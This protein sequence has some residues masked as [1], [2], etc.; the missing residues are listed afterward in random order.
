MTPAPFTHD[1]LRRLG[2]CPE[3]SRCPYCPAETPCHWIHWGHYQR[4]AGDPE[5]PSR[6]VAVP[7]YW[8]KIVTRTFSQLPDALLPYCSLR[9][10]QVL[11]WLRALYVER[12]DFLDELSD[13]QR[14]LGI[15]VSLRRQR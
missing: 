14:Q 15:P 13:A 5:D 1:A 9:T 11:E 8:C 7:R 3:P 12:L 6:K 2:P 10:G 4:Y